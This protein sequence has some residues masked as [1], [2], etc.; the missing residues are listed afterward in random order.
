MFL[1]LTETALFQWEPDR[2]RCKS[3]HAAHG[4]HA[5]TERISSLANTKGLIAS[6]I[7]YLK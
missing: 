3:L 6:D 7:P 5:W 1:L 4:V 2:T